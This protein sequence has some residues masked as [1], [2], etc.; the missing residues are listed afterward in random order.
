MIKRHC[1]FN[2]NIL[3]LIFQEQFKSAYIK[4]VI[5]DSWNDKN[6]VRLVSILFNISKKYERLLYGQLVLL[7]LNLGLLNVSA[8]L[9]KLLTTLLPMIEKWT[10]T[11][12]QDGNFG[13]I[14]TDIS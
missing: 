4:P 7:T 11:L 5:S 13:A 10:K 1:Q 12:H 14:S 6:N 9:E 8:N 3:T 2:D